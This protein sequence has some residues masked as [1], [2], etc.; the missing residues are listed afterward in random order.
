M[1]LLLV[2]HAQAAGLEVSRLRTEYL[3]DPLG[4][5][6]TKPRLTW[7]V[8]SD[9]RG[10]WQSAYRILVAT[11]AATLSRGEGDLWDSGKVDS[12]AT[13]NIVY[14][15]KPLGS[16]QTCV[17][18]VQLWDG[19]G[20][21][22]SWSEPARWSMGLL[23]PEDW[24]AQWIS[25][26]DPTPLHTNRTELFLPPARHYRK[27]FAAPKAVKRATVY[28]SALG[29]VE[30][31]LNGQRIGDAWFEPGWA[32]YHQRAHYRTHD[33]T[34]LFKSGGNRLGAIVAEGWYSGYVGYGLL[35]GY[36][37]NKAGRYFYG[38]TPAFLAQLEIE[39]TDGS[40]EIVGTDPTWQVTGDGPI[41]EAD[42]I[43]GEAFDARRDDPTWCQPGSGEGVSPDVSGSWTWQPAIRAEENG[44]TRAVFSD[45]RGERE[46]ELGFQAP[47]RLQAYTAPA[48]RVTQELPVR[49]LSQPKPGVY[50]FD[51]GQN[52]AG[53][54][55]LRVTG[56]AGTRLQLRF[57]EMLHPDGRLMTENLRRARATDY[58]TLRGDP[59]GETWTPRFTYHG[60]QFVEITG[61]PAR[62]GRDTVTGLVLHN[63]TPL[64]GSF[65]CSD[66]VM[67][68]FWKNTQWTQRANFLE[69]PTDCPQR[70][71]RLGWMGDA[72]VY[73]RTATYNADVAAFF[74][75]WLDDV[76][77][78][79]LDFGAYPDYCPY[80]MG[81]GAPGQTWGTAWTDA[82]II[83]PYT[84]WQVYDDTRVIERHWDSMTRFMDW[85]IK[86]APDFRGKSDGNM[87]GD[88][89]NVKENTPI[90]LID[91]AYFKWDAHLMSRMAR[92]IGREREAAGYDELE[93]RIAARFAADYAV[94]GAGVALSVKTQTAYVLALAFG[95]EPAAGTGGDEA[96]AALLAGMIATNDF[97]MATGFLGTKPLLPML[98]AHGQNDLALRL[99]QSRRFPSWGYEVEQGANSVW[100]R[101]DSFT[102]EHGFNGAGG[103][104]NASMNSFSHYSFGAVMEWAFRD[105]AG[106]DTAG[107]GYQRI[108]IRPH[109]PTPGSNPERAPIDWVK[110]EYDSIRGPI[111]S[112]WKR[113][114]GTFELNVTIPANTTATL[115][116]PAQS[117]AAIREGDRPLSQVSAVKFLRQENDRAVLEVG[118]GRYRFAAAVED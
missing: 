53:N 12:A 31:H 5:D 94:A 8:T 26:R 1:G 59:A 80:P 47:K 36:G 63:D 49:G 2:S 69:M 35:V 88:W 74:T 10:A 14:A 83:C 109:P 71:E 33:V 64:T 20:K 18:K 82:G 115:H 86:R 105:L 17:W 84:I 23:R 61:L 93:G 95:L 56:P 29:L 27:D 7:Q 87:W 21:P 37:P 99:F 68:K 50:I 43:M 62:P 101:W 6:E 19:N 28:A 60:F 66:E 79:Q 58:Y 96:R 114:A 78:A 4:I 70:D 13:V 46:V 3:T 48:I 116:L 54:V 34:S 91:A 98:T 73:V 97:R 24:K 81:H 11:E 107:P 103:D 85:R 40:K 77:E 89:L 76:E 38:K 32:D 16:G 51:L 75:K 112:E 117:A 67:T 9:E 111:V 44:S 106:I 30:L 39:Y 52:F 25:H 118:S 45:N 42:L 104:Q 102:K 15:G 57:G 92:A 110:A 90:E 113:G 55:R 72:Q 22:S 100:E 65:A 41:R 108:V